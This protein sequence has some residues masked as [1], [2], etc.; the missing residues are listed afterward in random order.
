MAAKKK[1]TSISLSDNAIE[2]VDKLA[3]EDGRSRSSYIERMILRERKHD[4]RNHD[5]HDGNHS[6]HCSGDAK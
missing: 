6:E 2:I 1:V 5:E 4:G 3:E